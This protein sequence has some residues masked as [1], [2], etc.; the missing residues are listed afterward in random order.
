MWQTNER[1]QGF[2]SQIM[3]SK[4]PSRS[5]TDMDSTQMEFAE[6]KAACTDNP[7]FKEQMEL[8][9]QVEALTVER[10]QYN[11]MLRKLKPRMETEIPQNIHMHQARIEAAQKDLATMAAHDKEE[12]IQL[13]GRE[14]KLE[15]AGKSFAAICQAFKEGRLDAKKGGIPGEY[16]GIP[17]KI[18]PEVQLNLS[19]KYFVK[20]HGQAA[21]EFPVG[22]TTPEENLNRLKHLKEN[23]ENKAAAE[24]DMLHSCEKDLESCRQQI[25]LPFPKE[26]EYQTKNMRLA[27]INA[28]VSSEKE[29][30][31]L[32]AE[33]KKRMN[34]VK[35]TALYTDNKTT[36]KVY[37]MFANEQAKAGDEW[38]AEKDDAI[39]MK[40][41]RSGYHNCML[42]RRMMWIRF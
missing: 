42:L 30:M 13:N 4:N 26:D 35:N 22:L 6:F 19:T 20:F 18:Q 39:A 28:V 10:V 27:E 17:F 38:T 14:V 31:E 9:Q 25:A 21:M 33:K 2:I 12:T 23:L 3:S 11:E 5:I 1:K 32:E 34:M 40:M 37:L 29:I 7:L 24:T 16:K 15:E 41:K 8:T 36:F